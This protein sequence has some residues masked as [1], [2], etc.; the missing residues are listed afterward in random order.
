MKLEDYVTQMR[1]LE[2]DCKKYLGEN[3]PYSSDELQ[4]GKYY[5]A[6][7]AIINEL[8]LDHEIDPVEAESFLQS[9][10]NLK[11]KGISWF[12]KEEINLVKVSE[13]FERIVGIHRERGEKE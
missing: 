9:C 3:N 6:M 11:D 7:E 13:E 10:K 5:E 2:L 12:I 8:E 1:Y 4:C